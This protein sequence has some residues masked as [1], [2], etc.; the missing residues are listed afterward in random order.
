M[1][2]NYTEFQTFSTERP[3][4]NSDTVGEIQQREDKKHLLMGGGWMYGLPRD[5]QFIRPTSTHHSITKTALG[6]NNKRL[7]C[8]EKVQQRA[9]NTL[10]QACSAAEQC[11]QCNL[12]WETLS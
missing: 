5:N 9:V 1:A 2:L 12:P 7:V 6:D 10:T 11:L 3:H 8:S 4:L